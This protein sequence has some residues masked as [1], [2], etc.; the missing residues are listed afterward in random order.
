M[1]TA[2][3]NQA[4]EALD[5]E[6]ELATELALSILKSLTDKATSNLQVLNALHVTYCTYV[7]AN[8]FLA[9]VAISQTKGQLQ[10]L[11]L[12][13]AKAATKPTTH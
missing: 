3:K 4:K 7:Q 8:P 2:T 11:Q 13:A 10:A 12:I 5:A 9:D 6:T 1:N